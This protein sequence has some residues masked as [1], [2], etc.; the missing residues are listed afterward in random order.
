MPR[1]ERS[2]LAKHIHVVV[3]HNQLINCFSLNAFLRFVNFKNAVYEQKRCI[4]YFE[5]GGPLKSKRQTKMQASEDHSIRQ[6][7]VS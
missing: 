2:Y 6:I 5:K 4:R 3:F 1:N 7:L